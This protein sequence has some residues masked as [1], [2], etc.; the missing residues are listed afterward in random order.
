MELTLA[1]EPLEA[2]AVST[3]WGGFDTAFAMRPPIG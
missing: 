1:T 2:W 3:S